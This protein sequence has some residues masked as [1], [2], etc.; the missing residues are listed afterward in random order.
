MLTVALVKILTFIQTPNIIQIKILM[1]IR[2]YSTFYRK[3]VE[4][5]ECCDGIVRLAVQVYCKCFEI[6]I[7]YQT[8]LNEIG[9]LRRCLEQQKIRDG[10]EKELRAVFAPL[11]EAVLSST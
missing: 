9:Y 7:A 8:A 4:A 3:I 5:S 1:I 11:D 2:P 6:V 10:A